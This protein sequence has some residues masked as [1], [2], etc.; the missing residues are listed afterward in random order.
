MINTYDFQVAHPDHF[1]QF[2]VRTYFSYIT[3][4]LRRKKKLIYIP[5]TKKSVC[6]F[7]YSSIG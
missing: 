1:K 3:D 2:N 5:T 7:A 6:R 4:V